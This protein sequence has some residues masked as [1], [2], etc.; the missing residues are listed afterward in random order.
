V[1]NLADQGIGWE[2]NKQLNIG[3]DLNLINN[4]INFTYNYYRK[5][6]SDL[7]FNVRVPRAS[8][9]SNVQTNI[10]ELKFWGH[11]FSVSAANIQGT[12]F[13]WNTDF[14]ISFD[15]NQVVSMGTAN[16]KLFTGPGSGLIGGSHVTMAGQPV[17][18]LYGMVHEGVY[19]NQAEFDSSPKHSTSQV[20]TAKFR[21]V[22][23]D[24]IITVDDATIIGNPHPD[25]IY[26]MTNTLQYKNFDFSVTV[27]G[28]S[29]NDVLR[30]SEQTLTNL[31]GVFNVLANVKDRWRSPEN[32]G[33]GR[34][35]SLANGTTYLERD[36]WGS[37]MLYDA[38]HL[39]INNI[40]LGYNLT[41]LKPSFLRS[42]RV[43][44]SIQNAHVFT[45]YPGGNPQVG[46]SQASTMLGIDGGSYPVPRTSTIGVNIGF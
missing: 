21:D 8:G 7:L 28:S 42:V 2:L 31:D 6:T 19:D 35:G 12:D 30:G 40:T 45:D 4:R 13:K 26:G 18:M 3:L 38:S 39:Y 17:G 9:F 46:Q 25:F 1:D 20:G 32:P 16:T 44:G 24:G 23:G 37:Q 29:G 36:W 43:Y 22:N 11:E 34:Y 15:R 27:S 14:N 41:K 5:N 10:G 33:S